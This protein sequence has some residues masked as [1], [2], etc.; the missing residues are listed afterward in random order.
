MRR[1]TMSVEKVTLECTAPDCDL[2][3]SGSR[4][5]TPM[6]TEVNHMDDGSF[7]EVEERI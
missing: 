2:G 7:E 3:Q 6:I 1:V 5:K 4:Y